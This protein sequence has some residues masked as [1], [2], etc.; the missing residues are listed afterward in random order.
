[1]SIDLTDWSR[2]RPVTTALNQSATMLSL[3]TW[4][5]P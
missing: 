4:A 2:A 5:Q 1:M 3:P